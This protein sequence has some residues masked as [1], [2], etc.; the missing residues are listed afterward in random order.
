[1]NTATSAAAG[2]PSARGRAS[3]A[4]PRRA[5]RS[6][7]AAAPFLRRCR[8]RE[9]RPRRPASG[10]G[11]G[12]GRTAPRRRRHLKR[13]AGKF[14]S[15][16]RARRLLTRASKLPA[17]AAP[18]F[19]API[20][21]SELDADSVPVTARRRSWAPPREPS[22]SSPRRGPHRRDRPR[23]G[24]QS[25][26]RQP[27][28]RDKRRLFLAVVAAGQ[29]A[30]ARRARRPRPFGRGDGRRRHRRLARPGRGRPPPL[31]DVRGAAR[32]AA[33]R[34]WKG[35]RRDARPRR[36]PGSSPTTSAAAELPASAH[37]TMRA[38]MAMIDA[39]SAT[40][41]PAPAA[42]ASRPRRSSRRRS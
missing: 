4:S 42:A 21:R 35:S 11:A 9:P 32:W 19:T 16:G 22:R 5:R 17:A 8:R 7:R 40:G 31:P 20:R 28:F 37:F 33:T 3:L 14:I 15:S 39:R 36:R 29:A 30:A 18:P 2:R 25:R 10:R 6:S 13:R 1:M 27:L 23:R 38:A 24:R 12:R 41:S 34:S 26:P